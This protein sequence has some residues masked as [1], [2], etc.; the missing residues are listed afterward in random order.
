MTASQTS[1]AQ[2]LPHLRRAY[3]AASVRWTTD[4]D[5]DATL[6]GGLYDESFW[7]TRTG[8][9]VDAL[10]AAYADDPMHPAVGYP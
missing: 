1:A 2:I 6:R 10:W 3:L 5:L 7:L 9:S 4:R 8:V